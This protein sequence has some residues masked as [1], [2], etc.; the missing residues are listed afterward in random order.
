MVWCFSMYIVR[1]VNLSDSENVMYSPTMLP[2][3][4]KYK[5]WTPGTPFDFTRIYSD[6]EYAHL[7]YSGRRMWR[8]YNLLAESLNISAT[9]SNLMT[10]PYPFAVRPDEQLKPADFFKVVRCLLPCS[11]ASSRC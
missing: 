11:V 3:A 1:A 9:Y 5:L 6:G 4:T 8:A 10:Q 2:L 7:Y